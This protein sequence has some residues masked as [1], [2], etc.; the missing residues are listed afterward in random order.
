[1]QLKVVPAGKTG[2]I[3]YGSVEKPALD[4]FREARHRH[5]SDC[6]HAGAVAPKNR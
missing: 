2:L 6:E 3:Y 1:M 4:V 5:I